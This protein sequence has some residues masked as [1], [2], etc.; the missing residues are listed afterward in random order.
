MGCNLSKKR[1]KMTTTFEKELI[2]WCP[3]C[4]NLTYPECYKEHG[5][6][7]QSTFKDILKAKNKAKKEIFSNLTKIFRKDGYISLNKA[8]KIIEEKL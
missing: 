2:G 7:T 5:H 8:K 6:L 1:V 3:K 4:E